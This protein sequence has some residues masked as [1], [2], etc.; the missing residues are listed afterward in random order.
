MIE[1]R[2]YKVLGFVFCAIF[3]LLP[4]MQ[5]TPVYAAEYDLQYVTTDRDTVFVGESVV[6]SWY[7]EN[8]SSGSVNYTY[9]TGITVRLVGGSAVAL[10]FPNS[11]PGPQVITLT[12]SQ[13]GIWEITATT[14]ITSVS[15]PYRG[16]DLHQY[17]GT[18]SCFVAVNAPVEAEASPSTIMQGQELTVR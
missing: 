3:V 5:V 6:V 10:P 2:V 13:P 18:Q 7:I 11:N 12:F 17:T 9:S 15:D 8:A 16:S 1:K 4:G 14:Y